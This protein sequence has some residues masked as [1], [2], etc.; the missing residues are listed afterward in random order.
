MPDRLA[1]LERFGDRLWTD[2]SRELEGTAAD[3]WKEH[4]Q[5][6]E[7]ISRAEMRDVAASLKA[8]DA[9]EAKLVIA[10]HMTREEFCAY[11]DGTTRALS[12]I[13]ARRAEMLRALSKLGEIV[14]R[15][16][17]VAILGALGL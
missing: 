5:T 8:G 14:A 13:A 12:G 7:R 9:V 2:V 10:A 11:R 6:I 4:R 16:L 1:P 3:W 15:V 17:G